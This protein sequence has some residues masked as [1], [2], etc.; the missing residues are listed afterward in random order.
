M[1]SLFIEN[2]SS[3]YVLYIYKHGSLSIDHYDTMK[4]VNACIKRNGS[5][6]IIYETIYKEHFID[7]VWSYSIKICSMFKET[8]DLLLKELITRSR[9]KQLG[10][11]M[12]SLDWHF[13]DREERVLE[14]NNSVGEFPS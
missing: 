12:R 2:D 13:C 8:D 14:N 6:P 3:Y 7:K 11:L 10:Y 4:R 9:M 5:P 1:S